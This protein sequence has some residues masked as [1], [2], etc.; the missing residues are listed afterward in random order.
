MKSHKR[1]TKLTAADSIDENVAEGLNELAEA[2]NENLQSDL[3]LKEDPFDQYAAHVQAQFFYRIE[4]DFP[5]R[6]SNGYMA[7]LHAIVSHDPGSK[8]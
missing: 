6:F 7:L 8:K 1:K 4:T 2:I 3:E 5:R